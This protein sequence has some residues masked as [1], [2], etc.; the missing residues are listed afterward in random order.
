MNIKVD[1]KLRG[2]MDKVE[3]FFR[4]RHPGFEQALANTEITLG[5]ATSPEFQTPLSALREAAYVGDAR[6]VAGPD[7]VIAT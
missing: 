7:G 6:Y 5:P 2:L 1:P 4:I 3:H